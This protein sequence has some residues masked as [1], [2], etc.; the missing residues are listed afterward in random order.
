M[1]QVT[2]GDRSHLFPTWSSIR[3]A[4]LAASALFSI[5]IASIAQKQVERG[6]TFAK[7]VAPIFQAR[8]DEC[9]HRGTAAPMSL[10]TYEEARPWARSIK[11]RVLL[12]QMPPWHLDRTVGI[13]QFQ[14]ERALTDEQINTI[15][16][17]V[18]GGAPLGDPKDLPAPQQ[19]PAGQEWVLGRQLGPP[20]IVVRSQPYAMPAQGQDIWWKPITPIGITEARWVR[21]V[22]MR[23]GS[24]AGRKITHHALA[25]LEQDEPGLYPSDHEAA[26]QNGP[27]LLMEWAIGKNYD[28][29]R[30]NTGKL[31][32]AGARIRWDIHYHAIGEPIRDYVELGIYLYPK[33][34]V[35]KY[36]TRLTIFNAMPMPRT[37]D[38]PPNTIAQTQGFVA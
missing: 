7:D 34:E 37:L 30:P 14:N 26:R 4:V 3:A 27:G 38:I 17:W 11:E 33:G 28:I 5:S 13:E 24:V 22:E 2:M 32:L 16:R 31:L 19:W 8:C 15:V 21:A 36:R 35:P 9:H 1:E 20:D 18:D 6:V 25:Q 29:Y 10:V 12:R 23:T